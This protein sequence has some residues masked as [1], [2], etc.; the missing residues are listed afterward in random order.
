MAKIVLA[1]PKMVKAR[2]LMV[3]VM[4]VLRKTCCEGIASAWSIREAS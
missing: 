1:V 3:V 4:V 2:V